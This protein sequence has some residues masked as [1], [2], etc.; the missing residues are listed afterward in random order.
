MVSSDIK[1]GR[2]YSNGEFGKHWVVRHILSERTAAQADGDAP[3]ELITYRVVVGPQR[4]A[5]FTCSKSE[6]AR[7]AKY[8]VV[9]QENSWSRVAGSDRPAPYHPSR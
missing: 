9:L 7:W 5:R 4:R 6:F 8:E 2:S 1:P 3:T